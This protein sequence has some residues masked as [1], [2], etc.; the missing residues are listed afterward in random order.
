MLAPLKRLVRSQLK[1]HGRHLIYVPR[2]EPAGLELDHDLPLIVT[3]KRPVIF[4]VGANVG[5][6][7]DLFSR[8]FP[9]SSIY[10]FEPAA[11]C[12][13]L[14]KGKYTNE[15]VR[16]SQLALSSSDGSREFF[17]YQ[18]SVLNSLLPL[19]TD[20]ANPFADVK[21]IDQTVVTTRAVDSVMREA[22]VSQIDLL[23][24]D[25]QGWDYEVLLGARGALADGKVAAVMVELNFIP[26]YRG[27]RF[28]ETICS[29][30]REQ[31]LHLIDFY[32]KVRQGCHLAW[33]TALFAR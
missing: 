11:D 17:Y 3:A 31:N 5:Q 29:Y 25:T 20:P 18:R 27:Q 12:F 14:L 13:A 16:L 4:D 1:N 28:G 8:L 23:K 9:E 32:E 19:D 6:S 7:I 30:L 10:A 24:I 26:M 21:M 22:G 2:K 33:C 15:K